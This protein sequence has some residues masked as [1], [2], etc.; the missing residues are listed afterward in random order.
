MVRYNNGRG[1]VSIAFNLCD[2]AQR[3]CSDQYADFVN[4]VNE[5][6]TCNHASSQSLSEVGVSLIDDERPDLGLK[7]LYRGGNQ[8]NATSEYQFEL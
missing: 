1:N 7:L 2:F 6:M 8:C 3:T 4:V 5:N